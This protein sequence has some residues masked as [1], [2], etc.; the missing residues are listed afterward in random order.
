MDSPTFDPRDD[1]PAEV[2]VP[3]Q[4]ARQGVISGRIFTVLVGS[5]TLSVI[6]ML[7]AWLIFR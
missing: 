6:A 3:A 2:T 5:L 1:R 4:R 7:I